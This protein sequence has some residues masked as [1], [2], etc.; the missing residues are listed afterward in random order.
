VPVA[1]PTMLRTICRARTW[2]TFYPTR[3]NSLTPARVS[4]R[5]LRTAITSKDEESDWDDDE[6]TAMPVPNSPMPEGWKQVGTATE[7][8][9]KAFKKREIKRLGLPHA[10][11]YVIRKPKKYSFYKMYLRERYD[12]MFK[13]VS[14]MICF[15]H[16]MVPSEMAE[17]KTMIAEKSEGRITIK[18]V[19]KNSIC[20]TTLEKDNDGK[21]AALAGLFRGPTSIFYG[22]CDEN[23]LQDIKLCLKAKKNFKLFPLGGLADGVVVN[24]EALGSFEKVESMVHLRSELINLLLQPS[25]SLIRVMQ[26][27]LN[28]LVKTLDFKIKQEAAPAEEGGEEGGE[29][30]QEAA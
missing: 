4:H 5:T 26:N 7:K 19:V 20:R 30:V 12:K 13:S 9:I 27:P 24:H 2:S 14:F 11:N 21:Y 8:E 1:S 10:K 6:E 16:D 22:T 18:P 3:I 15:Q 17:L 23:I 28:G 29:K 25:H